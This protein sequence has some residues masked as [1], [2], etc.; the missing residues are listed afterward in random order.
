LGSDGEGGNEGVDLSPKA[1]DF[2]GGE[3]AGSVVS[4]EWSDSVLSILCVVGRC[5]RPKRSASF[6][7]LTGEENAVRA[8][9]K[10]Y[11]RRVTRLPEDLEGR[12]GAKELEGLLVGVVDAEHVRA[13][14]DGFA[15]FGRGQFAIRVV[16]VRF[17][18]SFQ[19]PVRT[20]ALSAA[21]E[22]G[23]IVVSKIQGV[24]PA[25]FRLAFAFLN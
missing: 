6:V 22:R 17:G 19:A 10:Q 23:I 1:G 14:S 12:V 8:V 4:S 20:G 24:S 15:E 9:G 16:V 7:N 2:S 25:L 21:L 13:F 11:E 5:A 18:G 3:K